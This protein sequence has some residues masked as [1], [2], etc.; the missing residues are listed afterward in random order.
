MNLVPEARAWWKLHSVQFA[1][2][3]AIIVGYFIANPD[4]LED[5]ASHV[6]EAYRALAV[7]FVSFLTFTLP[8][9]LRLLPQSPVGV[10]AGESLKLIAED[11][12]DTLAGAPA[13]T[14]A[15]VASPIGTVVASTASEDVQSLVSEPAA[16]AGEPE[17]EATAA[18]AG[19]A[20]VLT[21]AQRQVLINNGLLPA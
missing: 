18:D 5:I 11:V 20:I 2:A 13:P 17:P 16:A 15:A 21:D 3:A 9:L 8:V 19:Q 4:K 10:T 7:A 6:P 1:A 14:T 12:F